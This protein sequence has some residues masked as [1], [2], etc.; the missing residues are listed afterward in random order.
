MIN[1]R[2]KAESDAA[3]SFTITLNHISCFI[4]AGFTSHTRWRKV[5]SSERVRLKG[6]QHKV[7]GGLVQW[8]WKLKGQKN[9]ILVFTPIVTVIVWGFLWIFPKWTHD[10]QYVIIPINPRAAA[11]ILII[12]FYHLQ[13]QC[14]YKVHLSV[15]FP[16]STTSRL[17]IRSEK[18]TRSNIARISQIQFQF[19]LKY[20]IQNYLWNRYC[21]MSQLRFVFIFLFRT[22]DT[23]Q[24]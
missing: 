15:L 14:H 3:C 22:S 10:N 5:A 7:F 19:Q 12:N 8:I 20:C 17:I 13:G 4:V 2:L 1:V 18:Y 24:G 23:L 9:R 16:P 6:N 11:S 21:I